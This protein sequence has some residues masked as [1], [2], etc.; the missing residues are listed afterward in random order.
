MQM[1]AQMLKPD[2]FYMEVV[3]EESTSIFSAFKRFT[4]GKS[5][6]DKYF[7]ESA[8]RDPQNVCYVYRNKSNGDIVG[9][10]TLCCSGIIMNDPVLV[11]LVPA[12]KIDYFAVSVDYQDLMFPGSEPGEHFHFSDAFFS[13]LLLCAANISQDTVG[14]NF[15]I[16]YAV[17]DAVYFYKRNLFNEFKEYMKREQ[18][19]YLDGCVP[20]FMRL[21]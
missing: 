6:I 11:Q 16:L 13:E 14:A 4:C 9:L 3:S 10:A 12:I 19:R 20:M 17:E 21:S 1:D 7:H 2:D 8:G 5:E 15:V 18:Y